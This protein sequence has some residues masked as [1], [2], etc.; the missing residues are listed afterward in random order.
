MLRKPRS[1]AGFLLLQEVQIYADRGADREPRALLV[2]APGF[3]KELNLGYDQRSPNP[4]AAAVLSIGGIRYAA[5][6]RE[7]NAFR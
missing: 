4:G 1:P 6:W 3:R 2:G 7:I 5:T